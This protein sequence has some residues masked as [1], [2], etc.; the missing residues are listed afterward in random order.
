MPRQP[1]EE[2]ESYLPQPQ[3][4]AT[5]I[6]RKRT[7][8]PAGWKKRAGARGVARQPPQPPRACEPVKL[9]VRPA[10]AERAGSPIDSVRGAHRCRAAAVDAAVAARMDRVAWP[11]S[12][13]VKTPSIRRSV[14]RS[15]GAWAENAWRAQKRNAQEVAAAV[16]EPEPGPETGPETDTATVT[17]TCRA[18]ACARSDPLGRTGQEP[19]RQQEQED[20]TSVAALHVQASDES[21]PESLARRRPNQ[22]S[23]CCC[24]YC[25]GRW[26]ESA[27][28][29]EQRQLPGGVAR[30]Q[31][32]GCCG[33]WMAM[34]CDQRAERPAADAAAVR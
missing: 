18:C 24:C 9:A 6:A 22:M 13:P 33:P 14:S 5:P 15:V 4:K 31:R 34:E 29:Q 25:S 26:A 1:Q 32:W 7:S 30:P 23:C 21:V 28:R 11:T 12:V 8:S 3:S 27:V 2:L 17:E 10:L 16:P 20:G 19:Q